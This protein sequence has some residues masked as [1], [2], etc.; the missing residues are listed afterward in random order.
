MQLLQWQDTYIKENGEA[1]SQLD[2]D[3]RVAKMLTPVTINPPGPMNEKGVLA[4]ELGNL[5]LTGADLAVS[6]VTVGETVYP[7]ARVK[8]AVDAL[9]AAGVP[10]TPENVVTILGMVQ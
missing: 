10:V 2:I 4:F 6:D 9:N 5:D 1:P 3:R 7:A 8:E